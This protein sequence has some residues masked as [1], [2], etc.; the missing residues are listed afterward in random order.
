MVKP[1]VLCIGFAKCG[2]TTFY[3]IM[4]K[5]KDI[6]LSGI[7]EPLYY[8]NRKLYSKGFKW[9]QKRYYPKK[10]KEKIIMEVNPL[11][12]RDIKANTIKKD[13]GEHLKI[14]I[15]IR[16][17]I[18]RLYSN[19]KMNL[20]IGGCFENPEDNLGSSTSQLFN[21]WLQEYYDK[22]KHQFKKCHQTNF[23]ASG[24]YYQVIKD[25]LDTFGIDNVKVIIFEDLIK[26]THKICQE[27]YKFI[28]ID[29]NEKIDYNIHSNE[30][31]RLPIGQLSIK[32]NKWYFYN[33]WKKL[34]LEKL[35][36]ISNTFCRIINYTTWNIPKIFSKR[37]NNPEKM[38][39]EDIE[40][41]Q[42]YY[43]SDIEKLSKLLNV[44]LLKKWK[45]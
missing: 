44:D 22:N 21:K 29:E 18:E 27:V 30:G 35:P 32:I 4:G 20:V 6:F 45:I 10:V 25:Y 8:N 40:I 19:F 9:Y 12:A 17:P 43:R 37:N 41:L 3:D 33:I 42:E 13:F 26:N 28:D 31:T 7:K 14:I 23:V 16:N 38:L 34:L 2:T 39:K 11:I 36:Y 1:N 15:L 24:E 5:H